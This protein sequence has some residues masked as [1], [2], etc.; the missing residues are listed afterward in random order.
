MSR[1]TFWE[2]F[3]S[4]PDGSIEPLHPIKIGGV[5]FGPGVR[6]SK[7]VSFGGIDL[8]QYIGRDFEVETENGVY[9]LKGVY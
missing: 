7:G 6:F 9:V 1:I 2:L 8:I 3:Q 5:Q 4:H